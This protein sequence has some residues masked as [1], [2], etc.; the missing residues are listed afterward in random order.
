MAE[1]GVLRHKP[2][3]WSH[4]GLPPRAVIWPDGSGEVQEHRTATI[5]WEVGE[6]KSG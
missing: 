6:L 1:V 2:V 4:K 3:M 5:P